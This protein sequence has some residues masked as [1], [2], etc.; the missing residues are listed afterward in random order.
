MT[1]YWLPAQISEPNIFFDKL[2]ALEAHFMS[3]GV[4]LEILSM[5]TIELS[6]INSRT[7]KFD[8]NIIIFTSRWRNLS[9]DLPLKCKPLHLAF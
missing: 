6:H 7:A 4:I 5:L 2:P 3:V 8:S 9:I 1:D